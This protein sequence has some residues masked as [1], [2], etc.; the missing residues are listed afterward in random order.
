MRLIDADL[1]TDGKG[2]FSEYIKFSNDFVAYIEI[3]DFLRV[4]DN[5]PTAFDTEKVIAELEELHK[6]CENCPKFE[7]VFRQVAF[8]ESIYIVKKGGVE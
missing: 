6:K 5:I 2:V 4:L 3:Q 7:K 8:E 1:L